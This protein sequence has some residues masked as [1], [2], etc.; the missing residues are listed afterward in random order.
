M[1]FRTASPRGRGTPLWGAEAPPSSRPGAHR[2]E[3]D[4]VTGDRPGGF[5]DLSRSRKRVAAGPP[6]NQ[7]GR[8]WRP[9]VGDARC[10]RAARLGA[11]RRR[12]R[13]FGCVCGQSC[14]AE[15]ARRVAGGCC[16]WPAACSPFAHR[17]C[18]NAWTS[19][20]T[21]TVNMQVRCTMVDAAIRPGT[22]W[23]GSNPGIPTI[24]P[25]PNR[26][27]T[28]RRFWLCGAGLGCPKAP[29]VPRTGRGSCN[30]RAAIPVP[31]GPRRRPARG[32][33][34]DGCESPLPAASP[35][36][37]RGRPITQLSIRSCST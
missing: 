17:R 23:W 26:R 35:P 30:R 13:G 18:A 10:G 8:A 9:V 11:G 37:R 15:G 29:M 25:H 4:G 12:V 36:P 21:G 27:P 22:G 34:C 16:P 20:H 5:G 32:V 2:H 19:Q 7:A 1:R 6:P 3:A 24:K 14:V 33:V 31:G 28:G